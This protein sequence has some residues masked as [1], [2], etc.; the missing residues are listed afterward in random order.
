MNGC[1]LQVLSEVAYQI[2][3]RSPSLRGITVQYIPQVGYVIC[4]DSPTVLPDFVFQF[5]EDDNTFYYKVVHT[6]AIKYMP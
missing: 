1:D 4:C 2:C 3:E 5:Q 6:S